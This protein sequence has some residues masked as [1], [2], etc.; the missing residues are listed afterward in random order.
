MLGKK[1]QF[2]TA[3]CIQ[4]LALMIILRQTKEH[5]CRKQR[6]L[7]YHYRFGKLERKTKIV[8]SRLPGPGSYYHHSTIGNIANFNKVE[9]TPRTIFTG[10]D[11]T[12]EEI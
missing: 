4:D 2:H 12:G 1:C 6:K 10:K 3:T 8:K 9:A 5:I 7:F 11:N